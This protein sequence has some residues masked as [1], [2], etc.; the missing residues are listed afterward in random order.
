MT[1]SSGIRDVKKSMS[2]SSTSKSVQHTLRKPS[3]PSMPRTAPMLNIFD[4]SMSP[5]LMPAAPCR[6]EKRAT[7]I[8]GV[9]VNTA[10]I[11]NPAETSLK[12]VDSIS[13]STDSM[14]KWLADARTINET[15]RISRFRRSS[16]T[17][18]TLF[19]A[20]LSVSPLL[21]IPTVAIRQKSFSGVRMVDCVDV[22]F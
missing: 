20:V 6:T 11:M 9:E 3:M 10:R 5:M 22:A 2:V 4:P 16:I 14:V 8:S 21:T 19:N 18:C 7:I 1:S 12:P 17:R 15:A 13:F